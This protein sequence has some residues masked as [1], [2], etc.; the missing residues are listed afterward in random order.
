MLGRGNWNS[1]TFRELK[2]NVKIRTMRGRSFWHSLNAPG[3]RDSSRREE[4]HTKPAT[5]WQFHNFLFVYTEKPTS[6]QKRRVKC[7]ARSGQTR[8]QVRET[9]DGGRRYLSEVG[10]HVGTS[11]AHLGEEDDGR[12]QNTCGTGRW[13]TAHSEP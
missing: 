9:W 4:R 13:D 8:A 7:D 12:V 2:N 1:F 5:H 3:E 10:Q 11:L 6:A